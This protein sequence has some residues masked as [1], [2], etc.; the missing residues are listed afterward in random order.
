MAVRIV[1]LVVLNFCFSILCAQDQS[2][3]RIAIETGFSLSESDSEGL[4]LLLGFE[5]KVRL[6]KRLYAGV[7]FGFVTNTSNYN[8]QDV[9]RYEFDTRQDNAV[10]FLTPNL[11]YYLD[12]L[13]Y[14]GRDYSFYVSSGLGYYLL[15]GIELLDTNTGNTQE[16]DVE[17]RLGLNL[18]AGFEVR[19]L[20]VGLEYNL[21]PNGELK[22]VSDT[23]QKIGELNSSYWAISVGYIL[24]L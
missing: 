2:N 14:K 18:R 17:N 11:S 10:V 23:I 22:N 20:K 5:P 1:L 6:A 3:F 12:K 9:T 16:I 15:S 19:R 8:I 21:I 4:S 24:H 13:T 7:R